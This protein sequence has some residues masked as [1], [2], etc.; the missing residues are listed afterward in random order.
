MKTR[1]IITLPDNL[2]QNANQ[3]LQDLV[4]MNSHE[5]AA[6]LDNHMNNSIIINDEVIVPIN[7]PNNPMP[8]A[9]LPLV[10]AVEGMIQNI[11]E[12][13]QQI[14]NQMPENNPEFNFDSDNEYSVDFREVL[15]FIFGVKLEIFDREITIYQFEMYQTK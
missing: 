3:N 2:N 14:V 10:L 5:L 1:E 4:E 12:E 15:I 6:N 9:N 7:P 13:Q 11:G 8:N